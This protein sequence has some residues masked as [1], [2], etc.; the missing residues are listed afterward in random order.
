MAQRGPMGHQ[1]YVYGANFLPGDVVIMKNGS[2]WKH[3]VMVATRSG[4]NIKV[5]SHTTYYY[6]EPIATFSGWA[7]YP[8]AIRQ[9]FK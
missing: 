4:A 7:W 6:H 2:T 1:V 5:D 9:Y 8:L 3:V